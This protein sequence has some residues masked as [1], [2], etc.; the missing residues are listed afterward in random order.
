MRLRFVRIENHW[1]SMVRIPSE[2]EDDIRRPE[3]ERERLVSE[4]VALENRIENLLCLHGI[5]GFK[6]RLK[7]AMERL[8]NCAASPALHCRPCCRKR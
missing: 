3:R 1:C 5:A 8:T 7:K 6:P 4:R 2:A